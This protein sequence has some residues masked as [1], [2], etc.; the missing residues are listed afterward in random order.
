M[1]WN[2]YRKYK[3]NRFQF[4]IW[5]K[6]T[7]FKICLN[8]CWVIT[9]ELR[10]CMSMNLQFSSPNL[11]G[12]SVCMKI[13]SKK[14]QEKFVLI[15]KR[16]FSRAFKTLCCSSFH[17]WDYDI[18]GNF[19]GMTCNTLHETQTFFEEKFKDWS[20]Y[21]EW[22]IAP[23]VSKEALWMGKLYFWKAHKKVDIYKRTV[24]RVNRRKIGYVLWFY[25]PYVL[26]NPK[27]WLLLFTRSLALFK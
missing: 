12:A 14:S 11:I 1:L 18:N 15:L 6:P 27:L 4:K 23:K 22:L 2:E 5:R 3:N 17:F 10:S 9:G 25:I 24:Y 19:S 26:E 20:P 7:F 21:R 13:F 8:F 16:G